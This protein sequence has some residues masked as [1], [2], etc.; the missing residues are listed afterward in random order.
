MTADNQRNKFR[1]NG[2]S[3]EARWKLENWLLFKCAMMAH[4][5][6]INSEA[7]DCPKKQDNGPDATRIEHT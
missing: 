6:E 3:K 2:L 4:T 5:R 1:G 7:M